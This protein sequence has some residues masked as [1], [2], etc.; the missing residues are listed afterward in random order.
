[1]YLSSHC[2]CIRV[3]KCWNL[4][5]GVD[6]EVDS[7]M[8]LDEVSRKIVSLFLP[9]ACYNISVKEVAVRVY[10]LLSD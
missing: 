6:A 5:Q 1:M 9:S 8:V 10:M 2:L 4:P 3:K 7:S